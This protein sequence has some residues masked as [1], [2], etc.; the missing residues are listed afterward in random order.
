[1]LLPEAGRLGLGLHC[2]RAHGLSVMP[3]LV[4]GRV[5]LGLLCHSGVSGVILR[6]TR[7]RR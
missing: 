4:A 3:L 6:H 1:M 5:L 7:A 2:L